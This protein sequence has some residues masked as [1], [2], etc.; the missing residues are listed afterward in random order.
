M[1]NVY[2]I[3]FT[4]LLAI[5][6]VAQETETKEGPREISVLCTMPG[7]D[8]GQWLTLKPATPG[9]VADFQDKLIYLEV[10]DE[11]EVTKKGVLDRATSDAILTFE[12]ARGVTYNTKE[13]TGITQ[14]MKN[15]LIVAYYTAK[16]A[17][18]GKQ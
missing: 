7:K 18:E 8:K 10:L 2:I 1:K 3:I 15:R 6:A 13:L 9:E 17:R 16:R 5:P 4:F 14:G 12:R 11:D